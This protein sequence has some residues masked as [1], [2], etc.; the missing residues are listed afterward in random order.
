MAK[1]WATLPPAIIRLILS[2]VSREAAADHTLAR[3]AAVNKD[4]QYFFEQLTF[5]C[6]DLGPDDLQKFETIVSMHKERR[7][8]LRAVSFRD[9]ADGGA[10]LGGGSEK[11]LLG[12]SPSQAICSLLRLLKKWDCDTN[13][14][15]AL[16]LSARTTSSLEKWR[17]AFQEIAATLHST[18]GS[19]QPGKDGLNYTIGEIP[20][21]K[22][23][24]V[25]Y[26]GKEV[27]SASTILSLCS[28][29]PEL[30]ELC[31]QDL[32]HNNPHTKHF[33]VVDLILK[34]PKT[35]KRLH[36]L[37]QYGGGRQNLRRSVR[38]YFVQRLVWFGMTKRLEE[39]SITTSENVAEELFGNV[40]Y[41]LPGSPYSTIGMLYWPALQSLTLTCSSLKPGAPY[42][43]VNSLLYRAG[44]AAWCIPK[45]RQMLLLSY[46]NR[47]LGET[48][49]FF[50]YDVA[51]E[52]GKPIATCFGESIKYLSIVP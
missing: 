29:I 8:C 17:T 3:Y 24:S 2:H 45:L 44:V 27:V 7:K 12:H 47:R 40:R 49:G 48:D 35:L 38:L 18:N 5:S 51:W 33:D 42:A 28:T 1:Y 34:L 21:V 50:R 14:R 16:Y 30:E 4:W 13:L 36:I 9:R 19:Y 37:G 39:L 46:N 15:L 10:R 20:A 23:F 11:S 52:Q 22:S 41:L 6:L 26:Q 32:D 31:L 25:Q 43:A